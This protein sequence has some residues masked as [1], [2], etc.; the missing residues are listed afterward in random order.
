M[1]NA[2][3]GWQN[4]ITGAVLTTPNGT[5]GLYADNLKND[6]GS[7]SMGWQSQST[8]CVLIADTQTPASAWRAFCLART[9]LTAA[10][11]LRYRVGTLRGC[12]GAVVVPTDTNAGAGSVNATR[13]AADGLAPDGSR[14]TI[15]TIGD[16]GSY[17]GV[18]SAYAAYFGEPLTAGVW[19][20]RTGAGGTGGYAITAQ[21]GV[22]YVGVPAAAI[23][24]DD[25]WR[26]YSFSFTSKIS[27]AIQL[28][29]LNNV[30]A[31]SYSIA[32]GSISGPVYYDS[33]TLPAGVR[34]GL[35]QSV[36]VIPNTLTTGS[37]C[38]VEI[39]DPSNPDGFINIPLMY[40]GP[41][42]QPATNIAYDSTLGRDDQTDEVMSR[43]G[44]EFPSVQW[45]RRRWDVS[46]QGIR[47]S[48][49]WAQAMELDR[50][51]R[52]GRNV[53]F[54]PNPAS[55]DVNRE[56]VY[57]R[58]KPLSDISFPFGNADRR[59]WRV[60]ITERL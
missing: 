36:H 9:N 21:D 11:T 15:Y 25:T 17:V 41:A 20:R 2:L 49:L 10:A 42:W 12:L 23:P 58:A 51:A 54:I 5:P 18:I 30:G 31:G 29:F 39:N 13:T 37:T 7:P 1:S 19:I 28:L 34:P 26:F 8:N 48:E 4:N 38:R 57:G 40:A 52:T 22:S 24:N 59:A 6:Q 53:L 50:F 43:G 46:M 14:G 47:G 35:A 16:G 32:G 60:R 55:A 44:A 45:T 56:T 27:G 3:F 33:T